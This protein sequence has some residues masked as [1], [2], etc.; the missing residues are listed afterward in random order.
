ML[1]YIAVT[2][3]A[4]SMLLLPSPASAVES[5]GNPMVWEVCLYEDGSGQSKCVWDGR[6]NGNGKGDS[7]LIRRGGEDDAKV[8]VITHYRAHRIILESGLHYAGDPRGSWEPCVWNGIRWNDPCVFDHK[9]MGYG[10]TQSF[11]MYSIGGQVQVD[12]IRHQFAHYLLGL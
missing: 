9:H 1:K 3:M 6:H 8:K 5:E 12:Y 10:G 2:L 11:A 4:A 7:L